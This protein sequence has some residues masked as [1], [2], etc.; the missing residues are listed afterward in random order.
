MSRV[1]V[2]RILQ[3]VREIGETGGVGIR[4]CL[5]AVRSIQNVH[6]KPLTQLDI[7]CSTDMVQVSVDE[8]LEGILAVKVKQLVQHGN[9]VSRGK[10]KV[11]TAVGTWGGEGN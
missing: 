3:N 1:N 11:R 10:R 5:G 4:L 9:I 8:I 2:D 6:H 7:F